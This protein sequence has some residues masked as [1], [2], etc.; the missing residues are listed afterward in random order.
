MAVLPLPPRNVTY[1]KGTHFNTFYFLIPFLFGICINT[2]TKCC[3][4]MRK[5]KEKGKRKVNE[6]KEREGK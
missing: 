4:G 5:G 2:F 1:L 3:I 6:R